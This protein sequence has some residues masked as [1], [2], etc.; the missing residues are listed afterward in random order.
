M[1]K[2]SKKN[3]NLKYKENLTDNKLV[4]IYEKKKQKT[5]IT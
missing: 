2:K 3:K 5:K 1:K 4:K